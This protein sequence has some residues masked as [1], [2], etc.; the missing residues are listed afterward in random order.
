M[1]PR[2]PGCGFASSTMAQIVAYLRD[3]VFHK[4][5]WN[6]P[7]TDWDAAF[8]QYPDRQFA[9]LSDLLSAVWFTIG[10]S[11][12]RVFFDRFVSGPIG[13]RLMGI[14]RADMFP[15]TSEVQPTPKLRKAFADNIRPS[16]A[17]LDRLAQE[18]NTTR[19]AI[20][21]WFKQQRGVKR[22]EIKV[23]KFTESSWRLTY[24]VCAIVMGVLT[25]KDKPWFTDPSKCFS[26]EFPYQH[27]SQDVKIYYLVSLGFYG[28]LIIFQFFEE[29]KKDFWEMF[30]HHV[31]TIALI[32]LSWSLNYV[33]IGTLVLLVHDIADP[34]LEF[35]KL[36]HYSKLDKICDIGFV[37][38]AVTFGISRLYVYPLYVIR[39]TIVDGL[40]AAGNRKIIVWWLF[41][42]L[43]IL[44]LV[45]HIYWY[46]LVL[47]MVYKFVVVGMV[48]KDER[49][50]TDV[51]ELEEQQE[52][53]GK[54]GEKKKKQN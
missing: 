1:C 19:A 3:T 26:D 12:F 6:P 49:S 50:A 46:Y 7:N 22:S 17:V 30:V 54:K 39:A 24:Y 20:S 28:H 47:R 15:P 13:M 16:S 8:K 35:A 29:A 5:Q 40:V 2:S 18:H 48:E 34:W 10:F 14:R 36:M 4:D 25:L 44:L 21:T 51:S 43:L 42:A 27:I 32:S 38:F 45:L 31:S 37:G 11:V 9:F 23:S 53:L 41:N 33:R 52:R